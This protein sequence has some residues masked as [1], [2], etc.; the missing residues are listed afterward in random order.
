MPWARRQIHWYSEGKSIPWEYTQLE[1]IEAKS[2][3]DFVNIAYKINYKSKIRT[4]YW[5]IEIK[6]TMFWTEKGQKNE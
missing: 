3:Y 2:T 5:E 4:K 6:K 1:Y